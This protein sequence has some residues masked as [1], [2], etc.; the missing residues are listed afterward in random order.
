MKSMGEPFKEF[1]HGEEVKAI[2]DA[3]MLSD[4]VSSEFQ[5]K[6]FVPSNVF[7]G[8]KKIDQIGNDLLELTM[9]VTK[10]SVN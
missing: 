7:L 8:I 3:E 6:G 1:I 2:I 5:V 10:E 9:V 4:M